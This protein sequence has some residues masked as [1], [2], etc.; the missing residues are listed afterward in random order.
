[1][2]LLS[3]T[4]DERSKQASEPV[5][6][7]T[8]PVLSIGDSSQSSEGILGVAEHPGDLNIGENDAHNVRAQRLS[9]PL[10]PLCVHH[11][12]VEPVPHTSIPRDRAHFPVVCWVVLVGFRGV[13]HTALRGCKS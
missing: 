9:L 7:A 5:E 2:Q 10:A 1:M 4:P 12:R 8:T 3:R 13:I 6:M 11:G